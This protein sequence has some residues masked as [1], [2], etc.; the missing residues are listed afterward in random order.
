MMALATARR[1]EDEVSL[2]QAAAAYVRAT[3]YGGFKGWPRALAALAADTLVREGRADLLTRPVTALVHE[4]TTDADRIDCGDFRLAEAISRRIRAPGAGSGLGV[5]ILAACLS[6]PERPRW[7]G[8]SSDLQSWY[9]QAWLAAR[10]PG[11][12]AWFPRVLPAIEEG[13]E[14]LGRLPGGVYADPVTQNACAVLA[15]AEGLEAP[16]T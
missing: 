8:E 16:R 9:M 7:T 14:P 1:P 13:L 10:L 12:R 11:G 2:R 15:L 5:D 4:T 6:D 3:T